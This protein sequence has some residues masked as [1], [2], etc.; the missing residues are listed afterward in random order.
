MTQPGQEEPAR[1]DLRE[2]LPP[3]ATHTK[4]LPALTWLRAS[5]L[6]RLLDNHVGWSILLAVLIGFA[7]LA[8]VVWTYAALCGPGQWALSYS[9]VAVRANPPWTLLTA[10]AA[11]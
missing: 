8:L 5:V 1:T 3:H 6:K 9:C 2:L 11:A 4:E 7:S 10:M